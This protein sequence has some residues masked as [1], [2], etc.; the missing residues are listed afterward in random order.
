MIGC[1]IDVLLQL[2]YYIA[3]VQACYK[4]GVVFDSIAAASTG[5]NSNRQRHFGGHFNLD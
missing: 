2:K 3:I 4:R 1:A 5:M